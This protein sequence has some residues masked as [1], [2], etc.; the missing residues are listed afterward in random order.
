MEPEARRAYDSYRNQV[1]RCKVRNSYKNKGI[2]VLYSQRDFIAWWISEQSKLN[3]IRPSCGRID[4]DDDYRFGNIRLEEFA[5]NTKESI[6]RQTY[7][8]NRIICTGPSNICLLFSSIAQA[9]IV[10]GVE[11]WIIE[12]DLSGNYECNSSQFRFKHG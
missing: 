2:E 7:R 8:V 1:R 6:S 3:L 4:H 10:T 12:K 11:K 9:S 5:D